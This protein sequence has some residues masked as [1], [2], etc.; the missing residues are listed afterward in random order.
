[1]ISDPALPAGD[2][3]YTVSLMPRFPAALGAVALLTP[4]AFSVPPA[5][6]PVPAPINL[7]PCTLP[8]VPVP[9]RCGTMQ[10]LE[11]RMAGRGRTIALNIAVIPAAGS[12][13]APD[14]ITF[15][16]G[17]PGEAAVD[18]AEF[19]YHRFAA[20]HRRHD[21]L[22]VDQRG[23]GHS[24][25]L[26]CHLFGDTDALAQWLGPFLPTDAI[27]R[28]ARDL[29]ARADLTVY[30]TNNH[31]DDIDDVRAALGYESLDVTGIS[32]G[33]RA[34]L[35]YL[36]RHGAHVRAVVIQGIAPTS[37]FIPET[38]ARDA[39]RAL[40][41]VFAECA[42][43]AAC[44]AAFP[45]LAEE[46]RGL[47]TH[48]KREPA[49]VRVVHPVTGDIATVTLN[50]DLFGEAIRYMLYTSDGASWVPAVVHAAAEGNLT[51][52]AERALL[53]RHQLLGADVGTGLY[54][55]VT[56]DEDVPFVDTA[57][58]IALGRDTF[59]GSY[60]IRDQSAA[61]AIW[62]QVPVGTQFAEPTRSDVPTL[63][64]SGEWDP[65]T[66]PANGTLAAKTLSRSRHVIVKSGGHAYD[67][68]VGE[69][70][71]DS[72]WVRFIADPDPAALDTSCVAAIHRS[73]FHTTLPWDTPIAV[74]T[75]ELARFVGRFEGATTRLEGAKLRL[76]LDGQGTSILAPVAPGRFWLVPDVNATV[77]FRG[78]AGKPVLV[79]ERDGQAV[80]TLRRS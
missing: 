7:K 68:L 63:L 9:A 72:L 62:P 18:G 70:C 40:D 69:E 75:T 50:R 47:V 45:R 78:N 42:G 34:S 3:R 19:V 11:N 2:R 79:L 12:P 13:R 29:S 77:S 27:T 15:F 8:G 31:V 6:R 26:T 1:M 21:I 36:K 14:A 48:L 32:Y 33:S 35:T 76:D 30:T 25:N 52:V 38:F 20:L 23:T 57:R 64:F 74:D 58:G 51:P 37:D 71:V 49:R 16:G 65:V 24:S 4:L 60:R 56:C 39:Q 80:R 5:P 17:G 67:G 54:L 28:C 22:L 66:P 73:G 59:L 10:V 43:D 41:G 46:M 55:A 53:F 44:H 61:C